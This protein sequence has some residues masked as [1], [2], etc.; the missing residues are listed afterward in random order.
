MSF[1]PRDGSDFRVVLYFEKKKITKKMYGEIL[2]RRWCIP[3]HSSMGGVRYNIIM[4][5]RQRTG[6]GF[7][8]R[9][10]TD[11]SDNGLY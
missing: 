4:A 5:L 1:E 2:R 6:D 8:F 7:L 10:F 9:F 3:V 11:A